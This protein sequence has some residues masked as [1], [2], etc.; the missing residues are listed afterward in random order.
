MTKCELCEQDRDKWENFDHYGTYRKY[1]ESCNV[2]EFT[3]SFGVPYAKWKSV[4][5]DCL[6][7]KELTVG[8]S[9]V[10]ALQS[11]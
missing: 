4:C 7:E 1:F 10:L 11:P 2:I 3:F 9:D 5:A 6:R 8:H